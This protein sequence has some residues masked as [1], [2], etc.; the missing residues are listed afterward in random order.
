[1]ATA[2]TASARSHALPVQPR[3]ASSPADGPPA[4]PPSGTLIGSVQRA[5]RLLECVAGHRYGAPAKQLARETGLALPT[6][7]HLLRT[8]VHE[9]YLR[10]DKGLFFLGEAAE[11][12][13]GS[14]AQQKRRTALTDALAGLSEVIGVPVYYARY[15]A[16]EIDVVCVADTPS[17]PA[18]EEWTDFRGTAHA[19]AVG[20]CLLAQLDE[21][22]RLDHL[23][24]HPVRPITRYTVRDAHT[25]L[26]RL[27][28]LG[29]DE[30]VTEH[31][32]Y[33]LGTV[34]GA[35]PLT[36]G[37]MAATLAVSLPVHQADR[38][39]PA[40][41]QLR[42]EAGRLMGTLSLSISM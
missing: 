22:A 3:P 41:R 40:V 39:L 2:D 23:G 8:L 6:A 42:S 4:D 34:C 32:E 26:K 9:G 14:A 7:Y 30:P 29:C 27:E 16:G 36:V 33:A 38:L 21:D 13:S 1:M 37:D 15:R 20:Q 24:R 10:R 35:I 28:R 11:R 31:Q 19:H 5:M 25:L 18:V 17:T 12:L